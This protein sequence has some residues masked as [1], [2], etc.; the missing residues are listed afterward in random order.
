MTKFMK[1]ILS[2]VLCLSMIAAWIPAEITSAA[3]APADTR[4]AD[5]AT[6]NMWQEYFSSTDLST[7][8]AGGVWTDKSVMLNANELPNGVTMQDGQNHFLIALSAVAANQQI[9]GYSTSPIDVMLVVDV[10]GSMQGNKAS[11]MVI[12]ANQAIHSLLQ[13]NNNNRVGLVVYSGNSSTNQDAGANTAKVLL[14]LDR[15]TTT[16]TQTISTGKIPAYLQVSGNNLSV[17]GGVRNSRNNRVSGEKAVSGG[18]YIQNGIYK[19]WQEFSKVTDVKVPEGQAQAGAQRTPVMVLLSDG[20]PTLATT[21]YTNIGTSQ[22]T[23]GNG[24]ES[25]TTWQTV[26][27][28]QLTAAW[29]KSKMAAHYGTTAKFYTLGLGTGGS[30][31]ATAVLDPGAAT[32]QT[33]AGY[34]SNYLNPN[35][36]DGNGRVAVIDRTSQYWDNGWYLTKDAAVTA[37]NYVDMYKLAEDT[38]ELLDAFKSI[39]DSIELDS[40]GHVTLVEGE[41]ENMSGYVTFTDELGMFIEVKDMK[42]LV[43][44][45]VLYTGAK[46]AQRLGDGS[47]GSMQQPTALGNQ[48][49]HSVRTR[50]GLDATTAQNLVLAAYS[51]GQIR[52]TSDKDFSNYLGWYSNDG[53]TYLGFWDKD[54]G[55]T[56]EG[57]PAGATWIN[58]SYLFQGTMANSDMMH[59]VV[60]VCTHIESGMQVVQYKIPAS[61]LPKITYEVELEDSD[62]RNMV[63]LKRSDASPLRL[64]YEVG[65]RSD[66]NAIN[67][68]ERLQAAIDAGHGHAHKEADG[69]YA[70]YTNLWGAEHGDTTVDY[71]DPMNHDVAQ[72]HF[73]PAEGNDRYYYTV[74]TAIYSDTNGT[75][76]KGAAAPAGDSYYRAHTFYTEKGYTVTY[77]PIAPEAL[78]K[79][80]EYGRQADGNWYVPAGTVFQQID[81]FKLL[82]SQNSTGTLEYRDHPVVVQVGDKYDTYAFLGNNGKLTLMPAQGIRLTKTVTEAVEGSENSFTFD[83]TLDQAVSDPVVTDPEGKPLEGWSVSGNVITVSLK[84]GE[85]LCV[86]NLPAGVTYTVTERKHQ[87]YIGSS[88]NAT[89]TVQV[90]KMNHVDFVNVPRGYGNLIVS[91][92]VAH[93]FAT[94]P[95]ALTKKT[96]PIT[97]TLSGEDVA[98]R[99]FA[100][101]GSDPVTY[102]TTDANGSFTVELKDNGSVTLVGLPEGTTFQTTENLDP[103]TDAGFYMDADRSVL[104][105]TVVKDSTVQTHVVN[106]YQPQAPETKV[107]IAGRKI[108]T[109]EAGTFDWSGKS[110]TVRLEAYDPATGTYTT[111]GEQQV[112]DG[113]LNYRFDNHIHLNQLGSYYFKVSEV[114][115]QERLEGMS[116]DATTGRIEVVVTDENV[117]GVLELVVYD[118]DTGA[119]LAATDG[120]VTYTKNFENI[121]TT[122]ATY[123]EF[124]VDKNVV[125]PHHTGVSE[126]GFLFDL[127]EVIDG[128]TQ[129]TPAYSMRTVMVDGQGQ[130]TFHIPVT[131]VGT[132]TFVL[133]EVVSAGFDRIPGMRYDD[134]QFTVVVS[135]VAQDGKLVGQLTVTDASGNAADPVFENVVELEP[136]VLQPGATKELI[137]REPLNDSEFTFTMVQTDGSFATEIPGGYTSTISMGSGSKAFAPITLTRVG[138]YY[139]RVTEQPGN[140]GGVI[141]DNSVY[142][143][144]VNVSLVDGKLQ[145]QVSFVKVGQ[146]QAGA[147]AQT[148]HFTN[149]YVNTDAQELT[150]QGNKSLT[151]RDLVTGEFSFVLA[152]GETILQTVSNRADG[153]FR[154]A[155]LVYTAADVGQHTYTVY[156]RND[157]LGGVT[158]DE[159]VYTVRVNVVDNGQ[160]KLEITAEGTQNITFANTYRAEPTAVSFSGTKYWLN[161]DL[162]QA[163]PMAGGEFRFCLY[164]SDEGFRSQ[165]ALVAS[166]TNAND[167]SFGFNLHYTQAGTY[168]YIL[169]EENGG[170]PAVGYD[171]ATYHIQIHVYDTSA[172]QLIGGVDSITEVGTGSNTIRFRNSYTPAATQLT[173]SGTKTL[174]G[175]RLMDGEFSFTLK[176]QDLEQTVTNQD[177]GFTFD[178]ITYYNSGVYTY[179]VTEVNGGL[180]GVTY[181]DTVYTVTVTVTDQGG[182]LK[183][184]YVVTRQDQPAQLHFE[185]QYNIENFADFD[186]A[187]EK[188]LY[189]GT[190]PIGFSGRVFR[191]AILDEN[192]VQL[193][194]VQADADGK[195]LFDN[196]PLTKAG[197]NTFTVVELDD[198]LGGITYDSSVFTVTVEV[199]DDGQGNLVSALP[200]VTL[201]GQEAQL[202]F[203]NNYTLQPTE[204]SLQVQKVLQNK[205]LQSGQFSF[206]LEQ[207]GQ[208]L[209]T[210]QNTATGE[211]TFD[212]ISYSAPGTY[213]YI[214]REQ[215]PDGPKNGI[216]YDTHTI[217]VT[218]T[219]TDNG[220]G[221]M[222]ADAVYAGGPVF[223]NVYSVTGEPMFT[224]IGTKEL[225]GRTPVNGEFTFL[226]TGSGTTLEVTNQGGVFQFKNVALPGL[227]VHTFTLTEKDTGKGGVDYDKS[228]YTVTVEVTDDGFGGMNVGQP[229]ITK[230][231]QAAQAV[232]TNTYTT[233]PAQYTVTARKAYNRPLSGGEFLFSLTGEGVTQSAANSADGTVTFETLT[234]TE[235]GTYTYTVK[236]LSGGKDYITYDTTVYQVVIQV[237]DNGEGQLLVDSVTVDNTQKEL[238]F[239]NTYHLG[240]TVFQPQVQ[241]VLTGKT[242]EAGMFTFWLRGQDVEMTATNDAAG[243]VSFGTLAYTEPGTYTYTIGEQ[244]AQEKNGITY[245]THT[246]TLTVTVTDNGDGTMTATG[247]YSG[248]TTFTNT[249]TVT[250]DPSFS[251]EGVKVLTGKT[252]A[253]GM[254]TFRLVGQNVDLQ[255]TNE[256]GRFRFEDVKLPGLGVHSFTLTE[257]KGSLGG[258]TYDETAY[259]VT[260]T[261]TDD[262]Q[263]GMVVSQPV[264]TK[265]GQAAEPVFT[266]R[267][268]AAPVEYTPSATKRYNKPLTDGQ[269]GF[270]LTGDG[271]AQTVTNTADGKVIFDTIEYTQAG[272]YTYTV[273]EVKG[274]K[275]YITYDETEYTL[276]VVIADDG[277]G[278]LYVDS[279]TVD[280]G[281]Q[282]VFTNT[283]TA[284]PTEY[285]LT[286]EKTYTKELLGNEFQFLLTGENVEQTKTNGAGGAIIFDALTFTEAGTYTYTVTEVKGDKSYITYDETVYTVTVTVADDGQ[287]KLFVQNATVSDDRQSGNS[288]VR[289][290]NIYVITGDP[291]F[292]VSGTKNL[293]GREM[294]DGEFVFVLTDAQGKSLE[295][296]NMGE[297]FAFTNVALPGLGE[298]T[299]TLTERN[300]GVPTIT[301][302]ATVYTVTVKVVDDNEGGM[303]VEAPVITL[304][305]APAQVR[306]EN[307]Y[308]PPAPI[309]VTFQVQKTVTGAQMSPKG[310]KFQLVYQDQVVMEAESDENGLAVFT[311]D[312]SVESVGVHEFLIREIDTGISYV[313]YDTTEYAV[314]LTVTEN[315]QGQLEAALKLN[316]QAAEEI[317]LSFTNHFDPPST[318]QT[319]DA[320]DVQ[321]LIGALSFGALGIVVM[322]FVLTLDRKKSRVEK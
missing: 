5:P 21:S 176:G 94:V 321:L 143:I 175:R 40:A 254:F 8:F 173:L 140:A 61:L 33:L 26:F 313:T 246:V 231:G 299:F 215:I 191:F 137:G 43:L 165:G 157:G 170:D 251:L 185:N 70:F 297:S 179:T 84:A 304:D 275:S 247:V 248:N 115:P 77:I 41:G 197:I 39:V 146:G 2:L 302:D 22:S 202:R 253:D 134:S 52:Y 76:Y 260:V 1:R 274:D 119:A 7:E 45:G 159:T 78:Q 203:N 194:L 281:S 31:Y 129:T 211:V 282:M 62:P 278:Q 280:S 99:Q 319:G 172:G 82:K 38:D 114:I 83:I 123:V 266:N 145:K 14:P 36:V 183:A 96:F 307:L 57:V 242:L 301:Y 150:L 154:F 259:T 204:Y 213:T 74:D 164:A 291:V 56:A 121:H 244:S 60:L 257:V 270:T 224:L 206:L 162:Q 237:V 69:S 71:T 198:G 126:A 212:A 187:G 308:T 290:D 214:I 34:W 110:F 166:T 27:L 261:V 113:S 106:V 24:S 285:V 85:T 156:E 182:Q 289:F 320:T 112:T 47:Y 116:Y 181:D 306:F 229:V 294:A 295:T 241:K 322:L 46:F 216:S 305:G 196:V 144:T 283:Y 132:R 201:N 235:P 189:R 171:T 98:N 256:N 245:D 107:V 23:Y 149:T 72:S 252:L 105:G 104:T 314:E 199:A 262:G 66:I 265:N 51:D 249:Y 90:G 135:G 219:V 142:H 87:D 218:V 139:Y 264:I 32:N 58:K 65:L 232:F 138:T 236:E 303:I 127:Y 210:K 318:P 95:Q 217:T 19:G 255:V 205:Q 312:C 310:F 298:H 108:L 287:G 59:I 174:I 67:V 207:E 227:G 221:T 296:T 37:K 80:A 180:G 54:T 16:S 88:Q 151:G 117:D 240:G 293:T 288:S 195:F 239:T 29:A 3:A 100:I 269:F 133:K 315:T 161:T 92:D 18:T 193:Q 158:Y 109:D 25:S 243:N 155:P 192:G 163:K 10:S 15:Y 190:A 118:F 284:A 11:T 131:K 89:G 168:Y 226:L 271:V 128:V 167:G 309:T 200:V 311:L 17:T 209:Q 228:V 300:T 28:S 93:P 225:T 148:I 230:N 234:F 64:V 223:T 220:D 6:L 141:Y 153:S 97:V 120:T 9:V 4:I 86:T 238:V 91:K 101:A 279:A 53:G 130:A 44:D 178:P 233:Q 122:D 169:R 48:F 124:T 20:Q 316:G 277:K 75:L 13:Q 292:S 30:E 317:T 63:S 35:K 222:T 208:V 258:V 50:L 160:G 250:G 272:T 263:G 111:L 81:R 147:D 125:D 188:W 42:G 49:I 103:V 267:Y 184:D 273:K 136:V 177:G 286:A 152:E 102:I 186:L 73:H 55:I 79:A 68:D 268:Q 276:T 12:A